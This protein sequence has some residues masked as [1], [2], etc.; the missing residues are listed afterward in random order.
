MKLT[1]NYIVEGYVLKKNSTIA[2]SEED[3]HYNNM[4]IGDNGEAINNDD[5]LKM[6]EPIINKLDISPDNAIQI[7]KDVLDYCKAEWV[8][9]KKLPELDKVKNYLIGRNQAFATV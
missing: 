9:Y 8:R 7:K 5:F 4:I 6:C 3:D 2:L 1:K